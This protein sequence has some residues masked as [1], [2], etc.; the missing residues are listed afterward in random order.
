MNARS[1]AERRVLLLTPTRRDAEMSGDLLAREGIP[2]LLCRDLA[3]LCTEAAKGAAAAIVTQE[4]VLADHEGRLAAFL[5]SQPPWSDFPFIILTA[6]SA[7]HAAD[8]AALMSAGNMLLLQRPVQLAEVLSSVRSA[9]RDRQRQYAVREHLEEQQRHS[10]ALAESDRRK[11]EFLAV[12]AHELRNPLAPLRTGI[13]L[14]LMEESLADNPVAPM[15]ERQ[16][17]HMVRLIDDLLDLSRISQGKV[18]LKRERINL[19]D[20]INGAVEATRS[21]IEDAGHELHVSVSSPLMVDGDPVRL[22][23]VFANLLTNAAKYMDAGGQI[24]LTSHRSDDQVVV[25]VEDDGLG[26]PPHMLSRVFE[27]FAQVNSAL[28]R[29]R[30]G[31]G[32]GLTLAKQLVEMHGGR[33]SVVSEGEGRGSQF[34]V[35]LPLAADA[36]PR[37]RTADDIPQY[38][39]PPLRVLVADDNSDAAMT[40]G[41]LLRKLGHKVEIVHDGLQAVDAFRRNSPELAILDIG[42]PGLNGYEAASSIRGLGGSGQRVYLAALTGWGLEEDRRRAMDAGFDAHLVKPVEASRLVGILSAA[43][44]SSRMVRS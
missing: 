24:R 39:G 18:V 40:L 3:E 15:M 36:S 31:L 11:G 38:S 5:L 26:I 35:E 29:S 19:A 7:E 37:T 20:V 28:G 16:I 32:I 44:S 13:E 21:Q 34:S 41:L 17:T 10:D 42:M 43:A 30:G 25:R 2:S 12:L 8:V 9:L 6:A 23:Q 1:E 27:M 22:S 14:L 33:I 4:A